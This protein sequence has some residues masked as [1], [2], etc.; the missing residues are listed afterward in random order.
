MSEHGPWSRDS[1]CRSGWLAGAASVDI[2]GRRGSALTIVTRR[3]IATELLRFAID[4]EKSSARGR[5]QL[6]GRD[7]LSR[8][9][10]PSRDEGVGGVSQRVLQDTDPVERLRER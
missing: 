1:G 2:R 5:P 7:G 6:T 3:D 9:T 8:G 10:S 4:G